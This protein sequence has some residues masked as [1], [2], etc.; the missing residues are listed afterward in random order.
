LAAYFIMCMY[1]IYFK[2]LTLEKHTE[3]SLL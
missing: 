3:R 2:N 1:T